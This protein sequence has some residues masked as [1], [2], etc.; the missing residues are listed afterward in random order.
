ML[1]SDVI[2]LEA[3]LTF[4]MPDSDSCNV[5]VQVIAVKEGDT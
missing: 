2:T 1:E 5:Q 4:L 3:V